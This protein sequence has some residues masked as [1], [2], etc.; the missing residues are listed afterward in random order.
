MSS[1]NYNLKRFLADKIRW[2]SE[3]L[4]DHILGNWLIKKGRHYFLTF[5]LSAN[6]STFKISQLSQILQLISQSIYSQ[7]SSTTDRLFF[8]IFHRLDLYPRACESKQLTYSIKSGGMRTFTSEMSYQRARSWKL[9]PDP[10][11]LEKA[12]LVV[13]ECFFIGYTLFFLPRAVFFNII[14]F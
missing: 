2:K 14:L 1:W 10:D 9:I 13:R 5:P 4:I 11:S 8:Q 7:F 3:N 6:N 12:I